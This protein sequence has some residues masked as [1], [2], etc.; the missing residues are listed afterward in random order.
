[1]P[2][3]VLDVGN[4]APD[5]SAIRSLVEQNFDAQVQ[6]VHDLEGAL[7][8]LENR[9]PDLVLVNR[10]LDIDYSDGMAIVRHLKSQPRWADIPVMLITNYPEYQAEAIA[11]GAVVGFG[12]QELR[13]SETLAKLTQYLE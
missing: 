11:A 3:H 7:A 8:A 10:K 1:M 2:K 9:R 4:C 5:H 13:N 6:Q 12:K